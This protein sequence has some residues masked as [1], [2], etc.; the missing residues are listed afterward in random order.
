MS[1]DNKPP[2]QNGPTWFLREILCNIMVFFKKITDGDITFPVE[3][4]GGSLSRQLDSS[5]AS[6][7]TAD[8]NVGTLAAG[9]KLT[10]QNLSTNALHVKYGAGASTTSFN[11]ILK[12]GQSSDDGLGGIVVIDDWEG[13]VSI[14]AATGSPR[15]AVAK[16]S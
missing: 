8:G 10:I 15:A 6:I 1:C 3:G 13:V 7:V 9:E 14:K 5:N 11:F 2:L 12:A 16:L 4:S